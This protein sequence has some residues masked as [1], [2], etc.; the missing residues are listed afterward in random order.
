MY[1]MYIENIT[2]KSPE[3]NLLKLG[4]ILYLHE[5]NGLPP[6]VCLPP[7]WWV[8]RIKFMK[9]QHSDTIYYTI[10]AENRSVI[11][12]M[13][14]RTH[15]FRDTHR[16]GIEYYLLEP[17]QEYF[18]QLL[19]N[20]ISELPDTVQDVEF[21]VH[22]SQQ[23]DL[24]NW[25]AAINLQCSYTE[26]PTVLKLHHDEPE[27]I[28][29]EADHLKMQ[30]EQR[31]FRFQFYLNNEIKHSD[32]FTFD[33]YCEVVAQVW[34]DMPREDSN[35]DDESVDGVRRYYEDI[36][37]FPA[38]LQTNL[39]RIVAVHTETGKPVGYSEVWLSPFIPE[40]IRHGD[41]GVIPEFRGNKLGMTM[42][43]I[44]YK[45]FLRD[46]PQTRYWITANAESNT[47]MKAI[48]TKMGH[49]DLEKYYNYVVKA[50]ELRILVA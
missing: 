50:D 6:E 30:A 47:H 48:N 17:R 32:L 18:I 21:W 45:K 34:N 3:E 41:T 27:A 31:G 9:Y 14:L 44:L 4:K 33:D 40:G 2:A 26:I 13:S 11:G 7:E 49:Q 39:L 36:E 16:A 23:Q 10:S 20:S 1:I 38:K 28:M 35:W 22:Q 25:L 24:V 42:K 12:F 5:S 43:M 37:T 46:N 29:E 19:R 8:N 15:K